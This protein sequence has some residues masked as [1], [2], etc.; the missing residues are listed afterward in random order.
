MEL[1]GNVRETLTDV[2]KTEC[3]DRCLSESRFK[4]RSASYDHLKQVS[5]THSYGH[6][7]VNT[8]FARRLMPRM[9]HDRPDYI[10]SFQGSF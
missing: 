2:S 10:L 9:M 3:Q 4:C 5:A 1:R 8:I 7:T 6:E